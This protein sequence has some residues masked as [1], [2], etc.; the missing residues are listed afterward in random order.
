MHAQ[1]T[2]GASINP[3]SAVRLPR[4]RVCGVSSLCCS[5]WGVCDAGPVLQSHG[6]QILLLWGAGTFIGSVRFSPLGLMGCT[7]HVPH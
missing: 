6:V 3:C 5:A 2:L 7:I 4:A 1:L